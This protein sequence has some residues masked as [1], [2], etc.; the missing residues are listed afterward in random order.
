MLGLA[1]RV[2][3]RFLMASTSYGDPE[4]RKLKATKVP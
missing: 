2:G 3:A 4:I 1:K